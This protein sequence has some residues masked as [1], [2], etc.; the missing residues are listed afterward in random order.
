MSDYQYLSE[1]DYTYIS[2]AGVKFITIDN[3]NAKLN[4]MFKKGYANT[5]EEDGGVI[6]GCITYKKTKTDTHHAHVFL[7][8]IEEVKV[9]CDHILNGHPRLGIIKTQVIEG[10]CPKCG[11]D[12]SG[13]KLS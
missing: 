5:I 13:E 12:P 8:P 1:E 3:A 11:Q 6:C 4:K 7:E 2:G 10:L 9:E